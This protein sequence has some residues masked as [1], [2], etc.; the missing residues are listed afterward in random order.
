MCVG[1][2][3]RDAVL[4]EAPRAAAGGASD[5]ARHALPR[6][7]ISPFVMVIVAGGAVAALWTTSGLT[8]AVAAG[9]ASFVAGWS[10]AWSP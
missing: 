3:W 9:V 7:F 1:A 8:L 2:P 5:A 6:L 4:R 10:S